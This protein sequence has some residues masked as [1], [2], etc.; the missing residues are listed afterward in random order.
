[1]IL[2]GIAGQITNVRCGNQTYPPHTWPLP[3]SRIVGGREAVPHSWPW[4]VLINNV[5]TVH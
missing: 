5:D 4:Q 2:Y 3:T 1:M